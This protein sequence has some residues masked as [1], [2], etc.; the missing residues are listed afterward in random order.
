M[1]VTVARGRVMSSSVVT[2][3]L[4]SKGVVESFWHMGSEIQLA[5][6]DWRAGSYL[7]VRRRAQ[8][9]CLPPSDAATPLA[10]RP[11]RA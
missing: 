2:C 11:R 6:K 9:A 8:T 5:H 1:A 10:S 3:L 7:L 4:G